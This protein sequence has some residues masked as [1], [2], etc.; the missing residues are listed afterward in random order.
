MTAQMDNVGIRQHHIALISKIEL[1]IQC[2]SLILQDVSTNTTDRPDRHQLP[3]FPLRIGKS[4]VIQ[5]DCADHLVEKII[6]VHSRI[7]PNL[8]QP[9]D[10]TTN[11]DDISIYS[12][13]MPCLKF[14][15]IASNSIHSRTHHVGLIWLVPPR[16]KHWCVA[17]HDFDLGEAGAP[18]KQVS[19]YSLQP[20]TLFHRTTSL[21]QRF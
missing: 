11:R 14:G 15:S 5:H 12:A 19:K 13:N 2:P 9:F 20:I 10:M 18:S 17:G 16:C 7:R 21:N 8:E 1:H 3:A 6:G 4:V